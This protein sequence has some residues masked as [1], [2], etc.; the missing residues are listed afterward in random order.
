MALSAQKFTSV[1]NYLIAQDPVKAKTLRSILDFILGEFPE[2]ESKISWNVPTI[3]RKGKYVVGV[4]AYKRHLTFSPWSPRVIENF[5]E[6]LTGHTL[7]KNCF[8]LPVDWKID[9]DLLKDLVQARL[10]ELDA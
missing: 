9:R 5:Q 4:C 6:R 2:L 10:A 7:F 8:H 1:E 3:H